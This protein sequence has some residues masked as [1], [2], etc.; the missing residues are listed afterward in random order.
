MRVA[1]DEPRDRAEP[2]PVELV[3]V[4]SDGGRSAIAPTAAMRSPSQR[5]YA[6][7]TTVTSPR[8]ARR[9]GAPRPAG[10]TTCARSRTSSRASAYSSDAD[11]RSSPTVACG[12]DGSGVAGV[13]VT[14]HAGPRIGREHALEALCHLVG[15]VGDDDHAR[16][17]RVADPDAAAV[18]DADP[19][20][21]CGRV[22]QRV[23]DR[24]VG[25]R[26]G[27]VSHRLRLAVR[28]RDGAGVEMV[29]SDRDGCPNPPRAD[30]VVDREPGTRTIA[31]AEP[32]DPRGQPLEGDALRAPRRAT[33]W[34]SASP[35]KS[36][37][38]AASIAAMSAG[39]PDSA[40]QRKGPM[41]RQKSGRI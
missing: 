21:S 33:V 5:T 3:D 12:V 2:A 7:S 14:H 40:A 25:D 28:R 39:S 16:V 36:S 11:G 18:V 27:A 34:R 6:S 41:P 4:T 10:E 22:E 20:R 15:A 30:E 9:S 24:P 17:D 38:S 23:E 29:A 31:V 19:G 35:G 8:A 26:V 37:R 13:D 32:A 1:V